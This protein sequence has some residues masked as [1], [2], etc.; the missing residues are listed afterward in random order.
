MKPFAR[1]SLSS[2]ALRRVILVSSLA[3]AAGCDGTVKIAESIGIIGGEDGPTAVWLTSRLPWSNGEPIMLSGT[4]GTKNCVFND[5][6][7]AVPNTLERPNQESEFTDWILDDKVWWLN[8]KPRVFKTLVANPC[9]SP[10]DAAR[11]AEEIF[12]DIYGKGVLSE[13]PWRVT[14]TNGCYFVRG[15]LPVGFLGGVAQLKL[16]KA[17]G[18]VWIY[19]HG[20]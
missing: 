14:D 9:S 19:L 5:N 4:N 15:T 1:I 6:G 20:K 3:L 13:R 10:A 17:D 18:M 7:V 2:A 16:E 8:R 11:M 12:V